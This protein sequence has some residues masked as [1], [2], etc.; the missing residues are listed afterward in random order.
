[1]LQLT[2]YLSN[3]SR[4]VVAASVWIPT[5]LEKPKE[6]KRNVGWFGLAIKPLKWKS[7]NLEYGR[8]LVRRQYDESELQKVEIP[9]IFF[10]AEGICQRWVQHTLI[11]WQPTTMIKEHSEILEENGTRRLHRKTTHVCNKE[12]RWMTVVSFLSLTVVSKS[13]W[14]RIFVIPMKTACLLSF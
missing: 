3:G 2:D 11:L 13:P 10:K 6:K 12:S 1:M 4:D 5:V 9:W 8:R 14:N 7:P